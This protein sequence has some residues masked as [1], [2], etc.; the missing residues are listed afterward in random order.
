MPSGGYQ[1]PANPAPVSGPGALSQRTDVQAPMGLP[2]PAYGEGQEFVALQ[3]AAP[4]PKAA[5]PLSFNDPDDDPSIPLTDG[6]PF[7][8]GSNE[9]QSLMPVTT[10]SS[11]GNSLRAK[12]RSTRDP[13]VTYL[14]DL[15]ESIG[16]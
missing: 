11:V 1:A 12:A 9:L 5:P 2:D 3:E 6:A 10:G 13:Y 8:P 16:I 7:G 4:L 14:A 15:A